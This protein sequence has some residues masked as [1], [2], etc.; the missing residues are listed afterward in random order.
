MMI[1]TLCLMVYNVGQFRLRETLKDQE[2]TLPNQ[3]GK[4]TQ[5]PTLRWVF[6]L[7]EGISVV[8]LALQSASVDVQVFIANLDEVKRKIIRN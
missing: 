6:R 8:Y 3:V 5:N 2:E 4:P 1:M 7:M